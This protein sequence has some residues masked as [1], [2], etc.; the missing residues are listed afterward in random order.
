MPAKYNKNKNIKYKNKK[1]YYKFFISFFFGNQLTLYI[2]KCQSM[3][4]WG[5]KSFT[6]AHLRSSGLDNI[7][8]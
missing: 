5:K 4:Y 7:T 3:I 8:G 1:Y 2:F 6:K